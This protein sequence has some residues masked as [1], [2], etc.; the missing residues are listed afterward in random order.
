MLVTGLTGSGGGVLV[1][2]VVLGM[3]LGVNV[4]RL[5]GGVGLW[6]SIMSWVVVLLGFGVLTGP[7]VLVLLGFWVV[8]IILGI[9]WV[10]GCLLWGIG[11][12]VGLGRWWLLGGG[13]GLVLGLLNLFMN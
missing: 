3:G 1:V 5:G 2:T 11:C 10:T 6:I 4:G 12:W 13:G 7:W 8:G 9:L